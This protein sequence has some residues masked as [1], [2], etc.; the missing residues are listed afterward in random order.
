MRMYLFI[1]AVMSFAPAHAQLRIPELSP[2][3]RVIQKIGFTTLE[4]YYERP[5][6]RGRSE[7]QIF[8][9]LVPFGKVW[10]TGAGNCT[11]I[12]FSTDVLINNQT[13]KNG[14]YALFTIPGRENWTI[15]LNTDTLA[16]GASNYDKRKDVIRVEVPSQHSD[17]YYEALTIDIDFIPN[18][19]RIYISWLNT[20]VAF[21]V[22]TGLDERILSFIRENLILR[23]SDN[24]DL[25]E[26]AITYYLWHQQDRKPIMRFIDRGI[27]L[28][29]DRLW[30]YWK[31]EELMK[32]ARYVEART[33][34]ESGIRAIRNSSES[35][36]RKVE[37]IRDFENYI[38]QLEALDRH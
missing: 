9:K 3:G 36:E 17:R 20:Q 16:Y 35:P 25:N 31:V 7:E 6:A 2:P 8:G 33:A 13:V 19:A 23:D 38:A 15:I 5:A 29:D 37:L 22:S 11:T 10:R 18:D 24:P 34:A 30:Y 26:S 28:K 27:A 21:D 12:S 14:K 1:I 32:D 4:V